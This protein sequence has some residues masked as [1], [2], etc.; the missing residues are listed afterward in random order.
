MTQEDKDR[1]V[2]WAMDWIKSNFMCAY[3]GYP[4]YYRCSS[5]LPK[6]IAEHFRKAFHKEFD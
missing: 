1:F 4:L 6:D 2:N 5:Y 3:P